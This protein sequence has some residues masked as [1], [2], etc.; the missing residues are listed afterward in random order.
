[1]DPRRIGTTALDRDDVH[2]MDFPF[3]VNRRARG[4]ASRGVLC[5]CSP[6]A[7]RDL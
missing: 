7:L 2:S 3:E 6:P 4:V 5:G 1:M